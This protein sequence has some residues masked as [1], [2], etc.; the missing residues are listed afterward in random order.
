METVLLGVE[1]PSRRV[2]KYFQL[3][4]LPLSDGPLAAVNASGAAPTLRVPLS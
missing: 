4:V 1:Q 2:E 3:L